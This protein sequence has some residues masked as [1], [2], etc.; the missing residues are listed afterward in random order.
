MP[1]KL[2]AASLKPRENIVGDNI[3]YLLKERGKTILKMA[4]EIGISH[5]TIYHWTQGLSTPDS[6]S[7]QKLCGYF[8]LTESQLFS[9]G[10]T[11]GTQAVEEQAIHNLIVKLGLEGVTPEDLARLS[12]REKGI[13]KE[14]IKDFSG[15]RSRSAKQLAAGL[16]K[17]GVKTILV[18]DDEARLCRALQAK[19]E[20]QGYRVAL[21]ADG[22]EGFRQLEEKK[23]DLIVLD[24]RMG[25]LDGLE[26]LRRLRE[27]NQKTKVIVISAFTDEL[28]N[29]NAEG[30][31]MEGYFEKPFSL[32]DLLDKVE[33]SIG[34][35]A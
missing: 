11:V 27:D 20:E 17:R 34:G 22:L 21:A 25:G 19:L 14:L 8:G 33:Q 12:E 29:I 16:T 32:E 18:I 6:V 4:K 28:V 23:P 5:K 9:K 7:R 31:K 1:R 3:R 26:F 24:L 13:L 35:A 30:L 15:R 10:L 2:R